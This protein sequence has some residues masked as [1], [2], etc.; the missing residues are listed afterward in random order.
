MATLNKGKA[1]HTYTLY[2]PSPA[3]MLPYTLVTCWLGYFASALLAQQGATYAQV[4]WR[5]GQA[6]VQPV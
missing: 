5:I 4:V 2:N 3:N 6:M 1:M